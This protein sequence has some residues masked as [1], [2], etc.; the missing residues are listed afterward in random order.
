MQRSNNNPEEDA[1]AAFYA[2]VM[3][4]VCTSFREIDPNSNVD[5][6]ALIEMVQLLH[7]A[8]LDCRLTELLTCVSV[9]CVEMI[10]MER[11]PVLLYG[12]SVAGEL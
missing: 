12:H 9:L 4:R 3:Q 10:E 7:V 5:V 8:V 2:R 11:A 6:A 1:V